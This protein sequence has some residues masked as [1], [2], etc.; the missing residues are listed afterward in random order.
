MSNRNHPSTMNASHVKALIEEEQDF[1]FARVYAAELIYKKKPVLDPE[2]L[3]RNMERYT[4]QVSAPEPEGLTPSIEYHAQRENIQ[5]E[6]L[7]HYFHLDY[8]VQ[9]AEGELPAQTSLIPISQRPISKYESS[10]QHSRHWPEAAA[11]MKESSYTWLLVDLMASG[12]EPK[13]RLQLF[14]D[15][16]LAV[17]ET[18]PADA[19][20]FRESDKL[21]EPAAWIAAVQKGDLLYGAMNIRFFPMQHGE[22]ARKE[23]LMDSIGLAALGIPDVQCHFY[24]LDPDEVASRLTSFGHD[25]FEHGKLISVLGASSVPPLPGARQWRYEHQYALAAPHRVVVDLDPGDPY[26]AGRRNQP[27]GNR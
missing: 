23:M 24:D 8:M 26:Y 16:L 27:H 14:T 13:S 6:Q 20:Y 17:L 10:I 1:G 25:L 12:L 22:H 5:K 4:G 2:T 19:I 21:V 3:Q 15:A 11:V 9:Y 18:A 7:L